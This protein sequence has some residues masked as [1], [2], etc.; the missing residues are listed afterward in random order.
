MVIN[1]SRRN[2]L[3]CNALPMLAQYCLYLRKC[4]HGFSRTYLSMFPVCQPS[5]PTVGEPW[6]WS[7]TFRTQKVASYC[8]E[9]AVC[10]VLKD[11]NAVHMVR[12][13]CSTCS[14][15]T[16]KSAVSNYMNCLR[17]RIIAL[18]SNSSKE[19]WAELK[20]FAFLLHWLRPAKFVMLMLIFSNS[21]T[22]PSV[23]TDL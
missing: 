4:L 23:H 14:I 11:D 1:K 9:I 8:K 6:S 3:S 22:H 19:F 17:I 7:N 13:Y 18:N 21:V 2:E 15:V 12:C 5:F 10:N 20:K 16:L